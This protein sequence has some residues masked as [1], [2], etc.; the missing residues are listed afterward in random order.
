MSLV[1]RLKELVLMENK[2]EF[3]YNNPFDKACGIF[4]NEIY[5]CY[6]CKMETKTHFICNL[7]GVQEIIFDPKKSGFNLQITFDE[8]HDEL[9]IHFIKNFFFVSNYDQIVEISKNCLQLKGFTWHPI[10]CGVITMIYSCGG[11]SK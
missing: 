3:V 7:L 10:K 9:L 5:N 11:M 1:E 4:M 2:E 6:K 8:S